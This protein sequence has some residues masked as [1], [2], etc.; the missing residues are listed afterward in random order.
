MCY[1]MTNYNPWMFPVTSKP[2]STSAELMIILLRA[3]MKA[4]SLTHTQRELS[5]QMLPLSCEYSFY[6]S[7]FWYLTKTY[8]IFNINLSAGPTVFAQTFNPV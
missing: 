4:R 8:L 6:P 3:E 2:T 7:R 1:V 5:T